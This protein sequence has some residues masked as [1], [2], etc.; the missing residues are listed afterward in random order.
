MHIINFV[1][2]AM[3][4][5]NGFVSVKSC[6]INISVDLTNILDLDRGVS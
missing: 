4:N 3:K 1:N 2:N 6:P 5:A